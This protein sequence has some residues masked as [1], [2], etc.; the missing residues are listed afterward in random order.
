MNQI[1]ALFGYAQLVQRDIGQV[2][3][4]VD[5]TPDDDFVILGLVELL[6]AGGFQAHR[7]VPVVL[8]SHC[9]PFRSIALRARHG[10]QI[11][12]VRVAGLNESG[13]ENQDV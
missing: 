7:L 4:A 10:V 9:V 6:F 3:A 11:L 12:S 1:E 2:S 5:A 8:D 13:Q